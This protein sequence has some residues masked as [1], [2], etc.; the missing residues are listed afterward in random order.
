MNPTYLWI[1]ILKHVVLGVYPEPAGVLRALSAL[2]RGPPPLRR[3][4]EALHAL[5]ASPRRSVGLPRG[6]PPSPPDVAI[7]DLFLPDQ[8]GVET[9]RH[10][11]RAHPQ[12]PIV[13]I[14]GGSPQLSVDFLP[15]AQGFGAARV[16][17]K[18]FTLEVLYAAVE[19]HRQVAEFVRVRPTMP[20]ARW[21]TI[22]DSCRGL[23]LT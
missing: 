5:R 2:A 17:R 7:V 21:P 11:R 4:C 12:L 16:L 18:P 13:A 9:I 10:L 14:P 19:D 3:P 8:R 6:P 1:G 15:I 20:D 23:R 22:L